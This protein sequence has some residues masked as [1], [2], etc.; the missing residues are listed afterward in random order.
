M[1]KRIS[2]FEAFGKAMNVIFIKKDF[3]NYKEMV[4]N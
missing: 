2:W 3:S 4:K 1:V